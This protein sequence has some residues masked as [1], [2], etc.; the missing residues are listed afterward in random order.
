MLG[1][2]PMSP[3]L[4]GDAFTTRDELVDELGAVRAE[5][6]RSAGASCPVEDIVERTRRALLARPLAI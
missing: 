2:A 1:V 4:R 3:T 5:V 6:L